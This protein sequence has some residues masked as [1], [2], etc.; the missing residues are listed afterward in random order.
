[1][2]TWVAKVSELSC[3]SNTNYDYDYGEKKKYEYVV[4]GIWVIWNNKNI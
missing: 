1:M 4:Y 3:K 2:T